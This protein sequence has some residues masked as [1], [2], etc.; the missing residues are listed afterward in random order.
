[1]KAQGSDGLSPGNLNVG[2]MAGRSMLDFVPMHLNVFERSSTLLP[3]IK[4]WTGSDKLELL[5]PQEWFTR[6]HDLQ[7]NKW[8]VNVDGL[9]MPTVKSG[10]LFG[11]LLW[12]PQ[13]LQL[14]N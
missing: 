13:K 12:L 11:L 9:K 7:S 6:G 8:E 5:I 1:M 4:T 2:V 14:K 10:F 3:W